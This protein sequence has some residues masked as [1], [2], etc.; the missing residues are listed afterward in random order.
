MEIVL[1]GGKHIITSVLVDIK[2][3]F[4]CLFRLCAKLVDIHF[5]KMFL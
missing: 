4:V 2:K 5:R 1:E 3:I